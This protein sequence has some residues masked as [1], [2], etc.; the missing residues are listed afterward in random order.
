MKQFFA[1]PAWLNRSHPIT[2]RYLRQ[3]LPVRFQYL[4]L[5]LAVGAFL[6][7]GGLSLP[8]LYC[9]FSLVILLQITLSSGDK[10]HRERQSATW[11]LMRTTPFGGQ[12]L[13]LSLWAASVWQLSRTWM[14]LIYR[15]LHGAMIVGLM[16]YSLL[17][18]EIPAEHGLP[19][20]AS[21]T[22]LILLQPFT[23]MYFSGMVG[24][25]GA[26]RMRDRVNAQSLAVGMVLSYWLAYVSV[27]LG[28]L[29]VQQM[30]LTAPQIIGIFWLPLLLPVL[31]GYAA[32]RIAEAAFR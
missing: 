6:L 19:I 31:L 11:D 14:M 32:L 8:V 13:L 5:A 1:V 26:N 27:V 12:E 18:A 4:L 17:F 10:V 23:E 15:L 22:L 21:G 30:R 3:S 7:L 16:V 2:Q 20:L 25:A 24:L 28:L 29:L 9:L